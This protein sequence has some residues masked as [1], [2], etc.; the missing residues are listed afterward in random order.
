MAKDQDTTMHIDNQFNF[1]SGCNVTIIKAETISGDL[2][3]YPGMDKVE[4]D[5]KNAPA[6]DTVDA[7]NSTALTAYLSR[8]QDLAIQEYQDDFTRLVE[9]LINEESIAE[10]IYET[11]HCNFKLFNKGR[12]FK[13]ARILRTYGVLNEFADNDLNIILESSSKDTSYRKSMSQMNSLDK[14]IEN[15]IKAIVNKRAKK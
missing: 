5:E 6:N 1:E 10:W 7:D 4:P 8:L 14:E 15:K 3:V 12:T 2:N 11:R 9:E 13:M